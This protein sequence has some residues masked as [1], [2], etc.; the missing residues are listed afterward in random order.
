MYVFLFLFFSEKL[1]IGDLQFRQL[2]LITSINVN[3]RNG[4]F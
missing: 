3:W 2:L 4:N 1:V